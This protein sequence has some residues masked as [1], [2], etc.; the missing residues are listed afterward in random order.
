M[1]SM[2]EKFILCAC[3]LL[4]ALPMKSFNYYKWNDFF[5]AKKQNNLKKLLY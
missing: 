5:I 2:Q 4:L 3:M 1:E